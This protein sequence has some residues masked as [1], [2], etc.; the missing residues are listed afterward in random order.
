MSKRTGGN[1]NDGDE[2]QKNKAPRLSVTE[3]E[4]NGD[5]TA[6]LANIQGSPEDSNEYSHEED[7]ETGDDQVSSVNRCEA[8]FEP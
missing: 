1:D 4:A 3:D 5:I 6:I 7:Q 2:T 8:V